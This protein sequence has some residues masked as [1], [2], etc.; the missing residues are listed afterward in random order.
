MSV[1]GQLVNCEHLI[2]FYAGLP[3][4]TPHLIQALLMGSKVIWGCFWGPN[5]SRIQD[6][7][8]AVCQ[9]FLC[10]RLSVAQSLSRSS[11]KHGRTLSPFTNRSEPKQPKGHSF[12]F[13]S[14]G[15]ETQRL[16][17]TRQTLYHQPQQAPQSYIAE[18]GCALHLT[19][20]SLPLCCHAAQWR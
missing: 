15:A 13:G 4:I 14:T 10:A 17:H 1:A 12:T 6:M 7:R 3:R 5:K 11:H 8:A 16:M 18:P 19:T 20:G 2:T 9:G